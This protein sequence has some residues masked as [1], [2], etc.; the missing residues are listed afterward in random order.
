MKVL[1]I[2]ARGMLGQELV[3][4]F[5]AAHEV[6]AWD[7]D[8][9]DITKKDEIHGQIFSLHP[10]LIINAAAYNDVDGAEKEPKKANLING[11]AVGFLAEAAEK[12]SIPI[13]H[14]SSDYVFRG[15]KIEGYAEDDTPDPQ[16]AYA[17]SKFAGEQELR[18]NCSK[19]YLIRLS[20]LFGK[21]GNGEG[22]KKSFVD[23]MIELSASHHR[24]S[25]SLKLSA[26]PL[27]TPPIPTEASEQ[28]EIEGVKEFKLI[29]EE[30]S[31]PT[32]APDAAKLTF[33][34]I[35]PS[36]F[37]RNVNLNKRD[38]ILFGKDGGVKKQMPFGIYHGAN[39][40]ACTWYGFAQEIFKILNLPT[41]PRGINF[42]EKD[43]MV[44]GKGGGINK[45]VILKPVSA[46]E[47]P[48]PAAR[49]KYSILLNTKLPK[50]RDWKEALRDYLTSFHS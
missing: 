2:G 3:K 50:Q 22:V 26:K 31:S 46:A 13:I 12:L 34:I 30:L 4:V 10:E 40:G 23:K 19:F 41:F 25:D 38:G 6:V 18:N 33:E 42:S 11:I 15:D 16:S 43:G 21:M 37:P 20:R 14:Y 39:S 7:K 17:K 32:Y 35:N 8:N 1:I 5:S 48:R 24:E 27:L 28:G 44:F 36:I 47:F 49:P 29:D 9:C 45:N